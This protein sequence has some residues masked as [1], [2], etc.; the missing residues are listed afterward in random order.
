MQIILS[1]TLATDASRRGPR[2]ALQELRGQLRLPQRPVDP[3]AHLTLQQRRLTFI[4]RE[5]PLA[6]AILVE[7]WP[8][9][10]SE[11]PI[12]G[13][14][15]VR[16]RFLDWVSRRLQDHEQDIPDKD[17]LAIFGSEYMFGEFLDSNL[18][19]IDYYIDEGADIDDVERSVRQ[20]YEEARKYAK[21]DA[22][23]LDFDGW[24]QQGHERDEWWWHWM[25]EYTPEGGGGYWHTGRMLEDDR[26]AMEWT[27]QGP[28]FEYELELEEVPGSYEP[29]LVLEPVI[30]MVDIS[31]H[32]SSDNRKRLGGGH[33]LRIDAP[34]NPP[35]PCL[36]RWIEDQGIDSVDSLEKL[37]EL[38]SE[39]EEPEEWAYLAVSSGG[40]ACPY[41]QEDDYDWI[42][43]LPEV[44]DERQQRLFDIGLVSK[45]SVAEK[46]EKAV[47]KTEFWEQLAM[48]LAYIAKLHDEDLSV[49]V[50]WMED[51]LGLAMDWRAAHPEQSL[52]GRWIQ[53]VMQ[54][55]QDEHD[56]DAITES[57][58]EIA[59]DKGILNEDDLEEEA[60]EQTIDQV[61]F[62]DGAKVV[63]LLGTS[64]LSLETR[65]MKHCIGQRKHGHPQ[66]LEQ[67]RTRVFSYR[68][69]D[70]TPRA[71]WEAFDKTL[72]T[73]DL[74]G[75]HNGPFHDEDAVNRMTWFIDTIRSENGQGRVD[76]HDRLNPAFLSDHWEDFEDRFR[77]AEG[78]TRWR[79][80]EGF[81][82]Y[83]PEGTE[84]DEE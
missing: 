68:R 51:G 73:S 46:I 30:E 26:A 38:V 57:I 41:I 9:N 4:R 17:D 43:G 16:A 80:E 56:E 24:A 76:R 64:A 77:M 44:Q 78:D 53:G 37:H 25:S 28:R 69:P 14:M 22:L 6:F 82:R 5:R 27:D 84:G 45:D 2:G 18:Q 59:Q 11:D 50:S 32:Y 67:G 31:R 49:R 83:E 35:P 20:A 66:L 34:Y 10:Q 65:R 55:A 13:N 61:I 70:G 19:S 39:G 1:T 48:G 52:E 36:K 72:V 3:L 74:Q 23:G 21:N 29:K 60:E 58:N 33:R 15:A 42:F 71:T 8:M 40:E 63:E 54:D 81:P 12:T 47:E 75:P 79:N 62:E 7:I